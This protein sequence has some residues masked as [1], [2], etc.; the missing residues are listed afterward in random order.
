M[1]FDIWREGPR[2]RMRILRTSSIEDAQQYVLEKY[3]PECGKMEG[4]FQYEHL[5][6][7][8]YWDVWYGNAARK[9]VYCQRI[10]LRYVE[11]L[12]DGKV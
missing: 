7:V 1:R 3:S 5:D 11:E 6:G 8:Y 12:K 4:P 10:E 2:V 9:L